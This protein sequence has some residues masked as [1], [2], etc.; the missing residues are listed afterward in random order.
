MIFR[1]TALNV[2]SALR[3]AIHWGRSIVDTVMADVTPD[4]LHWQPP[5]LAHS[6]AATYAHAVLADD[7]VVQGMPR[8]AQPLYAG[9]WASRTGVATPQMNQTDEWA[10][11][12]RLDLSAMRLYA[13][14]VA[15]ATDAYLDSL[16]D[17]DLER[18]V[19]LSS[20]GLGQRSV[21]WCLNVL[22]AA[23]LN[24]MAGE[25]SCLKGLQGTR[26]YPD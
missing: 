13:Q 17:S 3:E 24:N 9:D 10:H 16:S 23:H 1:R 2:H 4:Q 18:I 8:G 7:G 20:V 21:A 11:A 14:A 5:G 19:D 22:V 6:I 25:I 15:A 26:G 12:L